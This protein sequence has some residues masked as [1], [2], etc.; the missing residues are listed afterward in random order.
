VRHQLE[1]SGNYKNIIKADNA[2]K[3]LDKNY[4][5]KIKQFKKRNKITTPWRSGCLPGEIKSRY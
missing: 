1:P 3:L 5:T 2:K 4:T